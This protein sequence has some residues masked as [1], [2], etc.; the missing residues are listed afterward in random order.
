MSALLSTFPWATNFLSQGIGMAVEDPD[1][2]VC[3]AYQVEPSTQPVDLQTFVQTMSALENEVANPANLSSDEMA[4]LVDMK[5]ILA[6]VG[7]GQTTL[8]SLTQFARNKGGDL[9]NL[10]CSYRLLD[11]LYDLNNPNAPK[12]HPQ[13]QRF[14][15]AG[16][17][18]TS[19]VSQP[20][21]FRT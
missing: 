13:H 4:R 20:H 2:S 18:P 15:H 1:I 7:P 14:S 17:R 21:F 6:L 3:G 11:V 9:C 19:I 10:L 5:T 8:P 16:L 12:T